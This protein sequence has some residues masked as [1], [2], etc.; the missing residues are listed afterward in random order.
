MRQGSRQTLSLVSVLFCF[1]TGFGICFSLP[2]VNLHLSHTSIIFMILESSARGHALSPRILLFSILNISAIFNGKSWCLGVTFMPVCF[3]FRNVFP[4]LLL[5]SG[6]ALDS[7]RMM[8][9]IIIFTKFAKLF[10]IILNIY[11]YKNSC[12]H[13]KK[14]S[15]KDNFVNL[16]SSL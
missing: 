13:Y 1:G 4:S 10:I 11:I 15:N 14:S 12:I 6:S 8:F 3:T 2:S 16:L 7:Y 5:W 9:K